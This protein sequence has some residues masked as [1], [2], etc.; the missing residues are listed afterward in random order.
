MRWMRRYG[1]FI[2]KFN[3]RGHIA[4]IFLLLALHIFQGYSQ[5]S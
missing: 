1:V 5:V 3:N 2:M 4:L